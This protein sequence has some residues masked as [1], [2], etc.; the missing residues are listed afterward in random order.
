MTIGDRIKEA[1]EL[2]G[3]NQ[4]ELARR[5]GVKPQAI[6][7]LEQGKTIPRCTTALHIAD[8]TGV[9]Y[10][11]LVLGILP[12][13]NDGRTESVTIA[14]LLASMTP[15]ARQSVLE[16]AQFKA[17]KHPFQAGLKVVVDND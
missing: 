4:S 3:W 5:T 13:R 9:R 15:S 11:W 17:E 14:E 1:R 7:K 8:A 2:H 6:S 10:R 16:Y 12:M